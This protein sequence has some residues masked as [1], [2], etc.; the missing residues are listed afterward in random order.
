MGIQSLAINSQKKLRDSSMLVLSRKVGEQIVIAGDIVI[1]V[2]RI[3]GDRVSIGIEAPESVRVA[4]AEL[5]D[6]SLSAEVSI[7]PASGG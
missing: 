7:H 4:R 1:L 2:K 6:P 5:L 3:K